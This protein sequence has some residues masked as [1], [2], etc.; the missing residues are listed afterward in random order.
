MTPLLS[1]ELSV[2][3]RGK[4]G[5]LRE[6][7]FEIGAGEA[8][9]LVG[10]SGSGKSTAALAIL[11]LLD[12]RGA[13]VRGRVQFEGRDLLGL[14][15]REM[16]RVRGRDIALVLQS[17]VSALNPALRLETHLREA[18]RAHGAASWREARPGVVEMLGRMGLPAEEAFLR[19]YPHEVSVG[20]AQ[21]VMV[22]M[23]V[24][25][26]PRL[27]IADEPTS[28]L[29]PASQQD[30]LELFRWLRREFG[31]AM[32][33]ISH[34]LPS[35]AALADAVAVIEA[36]RVVERGPVRAV[37]DAPQHAATRR[38]LRPAYFT[39]Q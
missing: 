16:R 17:P 35:V 11:G 28:A 33:Y 32:L 24:M 6:V 19:R 10:E 15:E 2:D 5:A 26:R 22:G 29:D 13:A 12:A 31:M 4:P 1:V 38:L 14:G 20:Q 21:R 39:L 18:W 34:D 25:H 27:L 36:G 7:A 8:L 23:A 30:A 3:Y 9:G 37:F